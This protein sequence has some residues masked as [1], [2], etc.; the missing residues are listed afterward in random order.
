[1]A[2]KRSSAAALSLYRG[3]LRAHRRM[4]TEMRQ[5]GDAYVRS[6]FKLHKPVTNEAQLGAFFS[7][8]EEYLD[9]MMKTARRKDSVSMG[10]LDSKEGVEDAGFGQNLPLDVEL[11]AEQKAQLEKLREEATRAKSP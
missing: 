4:P 3:I 8:W 5:L 7:A 10:A 11:S 1:M 6:E 9:Q 2:G